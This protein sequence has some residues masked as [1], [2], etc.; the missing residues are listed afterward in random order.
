MSTILPRRHLDTYYSS[1]VVGTR[2]S[3]TKVV[4]YVTMTSDPEIV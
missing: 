3:T 1:I 2:V 4:V